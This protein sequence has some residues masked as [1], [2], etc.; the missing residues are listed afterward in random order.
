MSLTADS[1]VALHD[2]V[3]GD[4]VQH[5]FACSSCEIHTAGGS[6]HLEYTHDAERIRI[7]WNAS[8]QWLVIVH[9]GKEIFFRQLRGSD[10][11]TQQLAFDNAAQM[12]QNYFTHT[13]DDDEDTACGCAHHHHA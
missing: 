10:A 3:D 1:F 11:E 5:G 9:D 7:E 2:A 13:H 12:L 4:L 8:Q 6:H